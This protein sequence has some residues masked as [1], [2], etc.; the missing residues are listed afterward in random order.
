MNK[1][2]IGTSGWAYRHWAG[3]FYPKDLPAKDRLKYFSQYFKTVEI[4]YSFYHLP[5]PSTYR[6]WYN[7]TPA[8]FVFAVKASRFITHIKRLSGVK[9]VW[10]NF[11]AN[12][13]FLKEK[14]GP[15]LFQFPPFFKAT[16]ENTRN[17]NQFLALAKTYT[18]L[19]RVSFR[20]AFEFRDKSWCDEKIYNLLKKYNA[21]WV[22]A[23]SPSY[24][25]AELV[26]ANFVYL[27]MHGS[28]V[29]FS[30]KYTDKELQ[31]LAEEIKKWLKNDLNIYVYFNNDAYGYAIENA[32]KLS[33]YLNI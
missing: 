24:P 4:N 33:E 6:N 29:L 8:D 10:Q 15:I 30:S 18:G 7:Q 11:L 25:K 22:I 31:G 20:W 17:L 5:R 21:G 19:P 28:K 16:K 32:R 14:L 23:D 1:L 3:I 13:S 9:K 26:T 27:R 12:V 2:F